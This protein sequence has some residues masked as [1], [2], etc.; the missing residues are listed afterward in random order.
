MDDG[1]IG[2][3][4]HFLKIEMR[5]LLVF[6]K[7]DGSLVAFEKVQ[8][9]IRALSKNGERFARIFCKLK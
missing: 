1:Y 3:L 5:S 6:E 8:E 9:H 4:S 7:R 2:F